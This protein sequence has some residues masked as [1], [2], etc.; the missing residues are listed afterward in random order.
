MEKN[1]IQNNAK[2]LLTAFRGSSV[3]KLIKGVNDYK[4]LILPNDKIMD[5]QK[6]INVISK[7]KFD[8][9]LSFGQKPIIKDKV[10]IETVAKNKEFSIKTNFDCEELRQSFN[11]NGLIS[12]I[13]NNCGTSYC[14]QLYLNGL[15][16]IL[17]NDMDTKMVFIHIPFYKNITEFTEFRE[18]IFDSIMYIV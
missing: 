4:T 18:K 7:E 10:H 12:K 13:S 9:I 16:Y 17:Q 5:T 14:N 3:E 6:L 2:I 15:K 1:N 11:K 8:Y